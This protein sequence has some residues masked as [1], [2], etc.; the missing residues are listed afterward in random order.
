M[1]NA[2]RLQTFTIV[3]SIIIAA[4]VCAFYGKDY[5][6]QQQ[7]AHA[8]KE[9]LILSEQINK[10]LKPFVPR[11]FSEKN[12]I[13]PTYRAK[14][15]NFLL[16][17]EINQKLV[18]HLKDSSATHIY[19]KDAQ[20]KTL[21]SK[22]FSHANQ[23]IFYTI[24]AT[25]S[26]QKR[27]QVP[28]KL[29]E[30]ENIIASETPLFIHGYEDNVGILYLVTDHSESRAQTTHNV[31]K[32]LKWLQG[33]VAIFIIA[34][35]FF[36]LHN[37]DLYK[38]LKARIKEFSKRLTQSEN[39]DELTQL[40]NRPAFFKAIDAMVIEKSEQAFSNFAVFLLDLDNFKSVNGTHGHTVGDSLLIQ[41]SQRIKNAVPKDS[42][43]ARVEGDTF[44]V[45]IQN[46]VDLKHT[47][48]IA[49]NI[50]SQF[51]TPFTIDDK[52]ISCSTSLGIVM[53][54]NEQTSAI[55]LVR[56]AEMSMYQAKRNG[57][58]TYE[59][60]TPNMHIE[61][62]KRFK[63]ERDIQRGIRAK[64]IF[65][66]YQ[67]IVDLTTGLT[68]S[69]EAL[70]RWQHPERGELAPYYFIEVAEET[71]LIGDIDQYALEA[72]LKDLA[73]W[74]KDLPTFKDLKVN[75]NHSAKKFNQRPTMDVILEQL[76]KNKLSP[77]SLKIELT[78]SS[79]I[80]NEAL[81]STIFKSLRE[82]GIHFCMDDFGTGFS[83]IS[84]LRKLKFD[85]LKID[86]SFV[87]DIMEDEDSRKIVQTIITMGK[88]LGLSV[89][90][91]GV[92]TEAQMNELKTMGCQYAQGY[93]FAKPM[94]KSDVIG[95]LKKQSH[96]R[97]ITRH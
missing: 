26:L 88:N 42:V 25:S 63:T 28:L 43:I 48:D 87:K 92:E 33:F 83:S 32:A 35:I 17:N 89:T 61:S 55:D 11:L 80:E 20:N 62:L 93:Y 30:S 45:I 8:S 31:N 18:P 71:G 23:R 58:G 90:A 16:L 67:P 68:H 84:Y 6:Y 72:A 44:G 41:A 24:K 64:E 66:R 75:V 3:A 51:E 36:H 13:E 38:A 56:N 12:P 59:I 49:K 47:S 65:N 81:A 77:S 70:A 79:I 94:L 7:E 39:K 37:I 1:L 54:S 15:T 78:E 4:F 69:F 53:P 19:I 5:A 73:E 95:F 22:E 52:Q 34:C 57:T 85:M 21:F 40:I 2:L 10:L 29:N 9:N 74:H 91:E 86:R 97:R 50:L 14:I 76:S 82:K 27:I 96:D 46:T 60:F